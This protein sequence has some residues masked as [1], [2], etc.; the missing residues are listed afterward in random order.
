MKIKETYKTMYTATDLLMESLLE[1][2]VEVIFS[3]P[4]QTLSPIHSSIQRYESLKPVFMN[5]EQAIVHAA[6]GYARATGKVGVAFIPAGSGMTNA[7]TGIATAQMDSVP[8]VIITCK[9]T[10]NTEWDHSREVDTFGMTIP[11]IKYYYPVCDVKEIP[12]IVKEAF[13]VAIEGR[14]SPVIIELQAEMLTFEAPVFET[15]REEK[16]VQNQEM[17]FSAKLLE[18]VK[19]E[20]VSAKKP[21]LFIGGGVNIAGAAPF[22]KKLAERAQIPV[23]S[24]LMGIGAFPRNHPLSLGMLGM[25]GTYAANRAVH[26]SDLLICLGVRFS[27]RVTGKISGFSPKSRKIHVDIDPAEI[28]KIIQVDFPIVGNVKDFLQQINP[29][30]IPGD[31]KEWVKEVSTWQRKVPRYSESDSRSELKP[32]QVIEL[33]DQ[34]SNSNWT[35]PNMDFSLL[36]IQAFSFVHYIWRSRNNGIWVACC[37]WS[38]TCK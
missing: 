15:K 4:S 3:S 19:S 35:T 30:I 6:D 36:S 37:N 2:K 8:Q 7:I 13:S 18:Q 32:Q 12:K 34:Y 14:P 24:S 23:V 31:T 21:V 1:E 27:D 5:H 20:M 22:V 16:T 38:F 33:L 10:A 29:I 17:K 25:H 26:R 28:N 9:E 11:I